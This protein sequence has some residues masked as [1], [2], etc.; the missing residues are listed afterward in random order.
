V[1]RTVQLAQEA[2]ETLLGPF[3]RFREREERLGHD[4]VS[5][6]CLYL[7]SLEMQEEAW[8]LTPS[9]RRGERIYWR[10]E[11]STWPIYSGPQIPQ[12]IW[13]PPR[14]AE[15]ASVTGGGQLAS[16]ERVYAALRAWIEAHWGPLQERR[17]SELRQRLGQLRELA[18]S[19]ITSALQTIP[20]VEDIV[21]IDT[22]RGIDFHIWTTW[23]SSQTHRHIYERV[24]KVRDELSPDLWLDFRVR[25]R[26]GTSRESL[27]SLPGDAQ[28]ISIR[29]PANADDEPT[30]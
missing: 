3:G 21:A 17:E 27:V 7:A 2:E 5:A 29:G 30:S 9:A 12:Y 16:T 8:Q 15:S 10:M 24:L 19:R 6:L 28:V 18:I 23:L 13:M 11:E 4:L 1:D 20:D 26:R 14:S 22:E 25:Q